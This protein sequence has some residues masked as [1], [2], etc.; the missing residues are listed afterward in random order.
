MKKEKVYILMNSDYF[1]SKI[2]DAD[3]Q[4]DYEAAIA[5]GFIPLLLDSS[6]DEFK[7]SNF[8]DYAGFGSVI[9]RGW[10]ISS[11]RYMELNRF[12][13]H[14]NLHLFSSAY[15]YNIS[16]WG[17]N[18]HKMFPEYKFSVIADNDI[19]DENL[20]NI[21]NYF[22]G[23]RFF[24]KD[25]VKSVPGYE[26]SSLNMTV[27]EL[28]R[29]VDNFKRDRG[30]LYEGGIVFKKFLEL[31]RDSMG[32]TNEWRAFYLDG[33]LINLSKRFSNSNF[34]RHPSYNKLQSVIPFSNVASFYTVDFAEGVDERFYII[35]SGAG[36]VCDYTGND[37]ELFYRTLFNKV[38]G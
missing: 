18:I 6:A 1:D 35:E 28:R 7:I 22:D 4:T 37:F 3:F 38:K 29:I 12:C 17:Y 15:E 5:A 11:D 31:K 13:N 24:M 2:V 34:D 27:Q 26:Y 33:K 16:H 23:D 25:Y 32:L 36:E 30:E 8:N 21:L 14:K 10:M 20:K 9:Y 19:T